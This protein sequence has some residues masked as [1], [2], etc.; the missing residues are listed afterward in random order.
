MENWEW[1]SPDSFAFRVLIVVYVLPIWLDLESR[2]EEVIFPS[3]LIVLVGRHV[4]FLDISF[5]DGPGAISS[6]LGCLHSFQELPDC[7]GVTLLSQCVL[8]NETRSS[9][10]PCSFFY[11]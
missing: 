7:V 8:A 4:G 5:R 10:M 2:R 9:A 6:D 11:L 3:L 1:Y